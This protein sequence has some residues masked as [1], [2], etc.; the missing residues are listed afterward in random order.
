MKRTILR[1]AE[2]TAAAIY[3]IAL[4]AAVA[5]FVATLLLRIVRG[6]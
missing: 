1:A 4:A 2:E 5:W 3:G 6:A